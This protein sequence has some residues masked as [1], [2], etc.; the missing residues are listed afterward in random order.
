MQR[1]YPP[2]TDPIHWTTDR[3]APTPA[4]FGNP[5]AEYTRLMEKAAWVDF[6]HLGKVALS[7]RECVEFFGGLTT[8]QVRHVSATRS[9]YSAMLTPQGRFLWD[10]TL[11]ATGTPAGEEGLLLITEPDRVPALMQQIAFY[12]LRAKVQITDARQAFHLL[13]FVGPEAGQVVGDLFPEVPLAEAGLGATFAPRAG[14][15]LWRDPRHAAFGWR[16]LIPAEQWITISEWVLTQLPPAGFAAWEGYRIQHGLPRGGNEWTP[17]ATLPLEAGLL[18]MNGV[19][20]GKGCY[21]GQETTARTH[22]RGTLKRR[23]YQV[24]GAPGCS[25]AAGTVVYRADGRE[26]GVITS[27]CVHTGTALALLRITDMEEPQPTLTVQGERVA[28]R[29]PPW[30]G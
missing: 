14:L 28:V 9:I 2:L 27:H 3:D 22:H 7:G 18:E 16:L 30:A 19:D 6:S 11:L 10:F 15:H 1:F 25:W 20:F 24:V 5:E 23:L 13:G 8:N 17:D 29:T 4:D 26:S 21:V 12:R